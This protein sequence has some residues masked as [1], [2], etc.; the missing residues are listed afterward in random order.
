MPRAG[1]GCYIANRMNQYMAQIAKTTVSRFYLDNY[2]RIT[3]YTQP[4]ERMNVHTLVFIGSNDYKYL[5][6][7]GR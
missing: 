1:L 3:L 4:C 6:S 2:S 7:L 5:F